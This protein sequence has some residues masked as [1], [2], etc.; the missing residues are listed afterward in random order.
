MIH[1]LHLEDD[2]AD[3]ELIQTNLAGAGLICRIKL[4]RSHDAFQ[5]A[6]HDGGLD[7]I[8]GDYRQPMFNGM[9]A[10]RMVQEICPEIPFIFV[11]GTMGEEAAI[12]A[13]TRGATDYVLKHNLSRLPSAVQRALREARDRHEKKQAVQQVALM[14]FALDNVH[15]AAF[16]I[17]EKACFQYVNNAA[18]RLLGYTRDELLTMGPPDVSPDFPLERWPGHWN[19]L[20]EQGALTFE[21]K[22]KTKDG[23]LVPVEINANYFKYEGQDYDLGLV[24]DITNRKQV[25]RQRLANLRFLENM[26]RVN[27]AIQSA[28]DLEAM[29]NGF[30]DVAISI[31]ACDRA[32]LLYP[33]DPESRAWTL[34]MACHDPEY[35]GPRDVTPEGAMDPRTAAKFRIL[36]AAEGPVMFGPDMPHQLPGDG[37]QQFD[38]QSM[39][40]M[41]V[42]PKTGR[43]WEFGVHQCACTRT[44]TQEE[45]RLLHEV[46]RRLEIGLTSMLAYRNLRESE[47]KYRRIVDT[48]NEGIWVIGPDD[49]T[50]FVNARMAEM[51]GFT[52]IEMIGRSKTDFMFAKD[53]ADHKQKLENRRRGL[54]EFYERRFRHKD[55][56]TVWTHASATPILDDEQR[57]NGAFAMFTDITEKK[58]T[59]T[60]IRKLTQA[61]EQSPVSIVITDVHGKIEFV[62]AKFTQITDYSLNEVIGRNPRILKSGQTPADEYRRLW[63]TISSGGIWQGE[64]QNRKKNGELFYEQATIA[65]IRDGDDAI[66]H[67]V[68][69]KEDITD[70]KELEDRLRQ[71]Q[72]MEAIGQLAGGIAHDFNNI[73][74]AITGYTELSIATLT[75]TS[76][77]FKYLT[78]IM[79]ASGRAKDLINQI[80]MFSREAA[81]EPRP[82]RIDFPAK[83][84]LKLIRAT[85]PATIE[86]NSKMLSTAYALVDPTQIHQIVMNLC[87]NAAYA[88]KETGGTLDVHL[89]DITIERGGNRKCY[90]DATPGE[91]IRLAVSDQGDGIDAQY[92]HRIFDPF[93]STK[94]TGEGTGMGLSVVHG[95]VKSYDGFIYVRSRSGEGSTFEILIPSQPFAAPRDALPEMAIPTGS[96]S[97][98]FVDDEIMIVDVVKRM[99]ETLGYHVVARTC[100]REAL[101]AFQ[102]NPDAF[103]LVVTDMTMPKMSG[104]ELA[105]AILR[106]RPGF[107]IV[108]C[109]GFDVTMDNEKIAERG[110]RGIIFKPILRRDMATL[111][112]NIFDSR[113]PRPPAGGD[114]IESE[115][116]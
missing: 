115:G 8:L 10:L 33:C 48:A 17:D 32:Y 44:W 113:P 29:M 86:M 40:A 78:Q 74:S 41:A 4:V 110:L 7:I 46:G 12:Q 37:S 98:L 96:E 105:E 73:L 72:K 116:G 109:T 49:L 39:M 64:F 103:D 71:V 84:A 108:L 51:L 18:C 91:Y 67:Y 22:L 76:Q 82:V 80:L 77:V 81:Q 34:P 87:T 52:S 83:E 85:I 93:F 20:K 58:E 42:Y 21:G 16:M 90:P 69:V 47:V 106:I 35:S 70:R 100:G 79:E 59:E 99:L 11:S 102:S 43:P 68:A 38:V 65:P 111:V 9:S 114:N 56:R 30:L 3:A 63:K 101:R 54:S 31:F 14:S 75:P 1:I 94:K 6:L 13:L 62:N 88:M 112:R 15:E 66:T 50:T 107:P 92:I 27:R 57:F 95:I 28:D 36:L 2:L 97:I 89:S 24:R 5:K 23:C 104:L 55:G 53:I 26:D 25:E 60:S 61:I 45:E 19:D